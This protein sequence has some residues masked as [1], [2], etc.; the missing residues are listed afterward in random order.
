MQSSRDGGDLVETVLRQGPVQHEGKGYA[1]AELKAWKGVC[2]RLERLADMVPAAA[3]VV[4]LEQL[5]KPELLQAL[6]ARRQ[7]MLQQRPFAAALLAESEAAV[8]TWGQA[9]NRR[10]LGWHEQARKLLASID[11]ELALIEVGVVLP[12]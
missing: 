11:E 8:S 12:W 6:L 9:C 3:M 7:A 1:T 4:E 2:L 5:S 10:L